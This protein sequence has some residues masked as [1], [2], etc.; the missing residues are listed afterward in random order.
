MKTKVIFI[1]KKQKRFFLKSTITKKQNKMSFSSSANCQYFLPTLKYAA[2]KKIFTSRKEASF[3]PSLLNDRARKFKLGKKQYL[4][5]LIIYEKNK[6][7]TLV[8]FSMRA[9]PEISIL[10]SLQLPSSKRIVKIKIKSCEDCQFLFLLVSSACNFLHHVRQQIFI[11]V[12]LNSKYVLKSNS[13]QVR[14]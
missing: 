7:C 2:S 3:A 1:K 10:S 8:L 14:L 5:G 6:V 13:L 4:P 12:H 9:G 11:V